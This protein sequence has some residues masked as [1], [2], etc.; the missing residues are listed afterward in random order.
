MASACARGF[1]ADKLIF[2]TD[3]EGVRDQSGQTCAQLT[4]NQALRLILHGTVTGGMQAKIEAALTAIRQGAGEVLIAP[5]AQVDIIQA[6]LSG[7]SAGT[8]LVSK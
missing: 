5:G 4:T 2:L 7:S 1:G 8:R 3:V 6:L